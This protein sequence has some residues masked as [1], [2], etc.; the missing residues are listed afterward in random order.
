MT[1]RVKTQVLPILKHFP[2]LSVSFSLLFVV[3]IKFM[4]GTVT[5][6]EVVVVGLRPCAFHPVS[7]QRPR[8]G[9]AQ[10]TLLPRL[11]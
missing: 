11:L 2:V 3:V 5:V 1:L 8:R 7:V 9:P 6:A 10:V 4:F